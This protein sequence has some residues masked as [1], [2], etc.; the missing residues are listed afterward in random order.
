MIEIDKLPAGTNIETL[1]PGMYSFS[2]EEISLMESRIIASI[3]VFAE[4]IV[5]KSGKLVMLDMDFAK[6][7]KMCAKYNGEYLPPIT[8]RK[9]QPCNPYYKE[10]SWQ[11]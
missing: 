9:H 11:R 10:E 2:I 3:A 1:T 5:G 4:T 7:E 6:F 8:Q